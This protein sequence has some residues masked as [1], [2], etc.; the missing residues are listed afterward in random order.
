MRNGDNDNRYSSP[1][2]RIISEERRGHGGNSEQTIRNAIG[3]EIWTVHEAQVRLHEAFIRRKAPASL[4]HVLNTGYK[5][6]I[7][8]FIY[9]QLLEMCFRVFRT[10]MDAELQRA[11]RHSRLAGS[12]WN[13]L[14][15]DYNNYSRRQG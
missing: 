7:F 5:Y 11:G 14:P 12:Q 6:N 4:P 15:T 9:S 13:G 10:L 2:Q 3:I 8:H 1:S